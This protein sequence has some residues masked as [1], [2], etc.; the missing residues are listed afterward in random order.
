VRLYLLIAVI[1]AVSLAL[2]R[3]E[4][5]LKLLARCQ[6]QDPIQALHVAQRDGLQ[7]YLPVPL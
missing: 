5:M 2:R 3:A 1:I 6:P 4:H 7:R